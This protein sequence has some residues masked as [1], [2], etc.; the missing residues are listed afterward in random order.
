MNECWLTWR[1]QDEN[2]EHEAPFIQGVSK[3]SQV[4]WETEQVLGTR[5]TSSKDKKRRFKREGVKWVYEKL[6]HSLRYRNRVVITWEDSLEPLVWDS[7][8][9]WDSL[10]RS[11][12]F[13]KLFVSLKHDLFPQDFDSSSS[14]REH[15]LIQS[16]S[17]RKRFMHFC[18]RILLSSFTTKGWTKD[19]WS[20]FS[21]T[22]SRP[23]M[24]YTVTSSLMIVGVR[25]M[26]AHVNNYIEKMLSPEL[27][28]IDMTGN[29]LILPLSSLTLDFKINRFTRKRKNFDG[30]DQRKL[31]SNIACHFVIN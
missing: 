16:C 5:V 2:E 13:S 7:E 24:L 20:L 21:V 27:R 26:N 30:N 31:S 19:P 14:F 4:V 1:N 8:K 9:P 10:E 11:H 6:F 23:E 18:Q 29:V 15:S 12:S 3:P 25:E 17:L 22:T 28:S